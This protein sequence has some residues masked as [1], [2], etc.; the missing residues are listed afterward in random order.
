MD[1][2]VAKEP[3]QEA[4]LGALMREVLADN[5]ETRKILGRA[6]RREPDATALILNVEALLAIDGAIRYAA[7]TRARAI[8][9]VEAEDP[10]G[11]PR[12]HRTPA[13]GAQ[14]PLMVLVPPLAS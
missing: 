3:P 5:A 13:Q 1:S 6:I 2:A 14:H 7:G 4:D 10:P 9:G 12:Y 8:T 11:A